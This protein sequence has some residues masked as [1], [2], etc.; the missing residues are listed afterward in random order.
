MPK[1]DAD[2]HGGLE[3]FEKLDDPILPLSIRPKALQMKCI[4][5]ILIT[6]LNLKIKYVCKGNFKYKYGIWKT[7][8]L[9]VDWV[10]SS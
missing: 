1:P 10:S 4:K 2:P 5:K 3:D 9:Y 8:D 7:S 6:F